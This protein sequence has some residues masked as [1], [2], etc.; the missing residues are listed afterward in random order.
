MLRITHRRQLGRGAPPRNWYA[1]LVC[2]A[3]CLSL[4]KN[5]NHAMSAPGNGCPDTMRPEMRIL[6]ALLLFCAV[7]GR[8][9]ETLPPSIPPAP[10]KMVT[11]YTMR[12]IE[13]AVG[14][15]ALAEP[16]K[17]YVVQ[18]TGW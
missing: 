6:C 3:K 5:A 4:H 11:Q 9:Q 14:T 16:G 13:V 17:V 18:Y 1:Q 8:S 10:G 2:H 15:G 7:S 12:Y